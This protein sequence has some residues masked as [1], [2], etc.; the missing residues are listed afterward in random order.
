MQQSGEIM[1]FNAKP[2]SMFAGASALVL[3]IGRIVFLLDWIS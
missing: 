2:Q 1:R 3:T